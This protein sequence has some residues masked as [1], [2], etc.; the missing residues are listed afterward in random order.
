MPDKVPTDATLVHPGKM[1][2]TWHTGVDILRCAGP[3]AR[4]RFQ[5]PSGKLPPLAP[6]N[7]LIAV[8]MQATV[9]HTPHLPCP[10]IRESDAAFAPS[11]RKSHS[12]WYSTTSSCLA[13]RNARSMSRNSFSVTRLMSAEAMPWKLPERM[14]R[15]RSHP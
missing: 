12:V 2:Y 15:A 4:L 11:E 5:M 9:P 6:C 13:L 14:C 3:Y 1:L 8:L 10:N 7:R